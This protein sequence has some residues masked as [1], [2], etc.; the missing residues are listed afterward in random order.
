MQEQLDITYTDTWDTLH[1]RLNE[2]QMTYQECLQS[3][4]WFAAVRKAN[5]RGCYNLCEFC[6]SPRDDLH[7]SSYKLLLTQRELRNVYP[8]CNEHHT[9]L[10]N[11]ARTYG[12]SVRLATNILRST[13]NRLSRET[14]EMINPHCMKE[15]PD[16][17][18]QYK[19]CKTLDLLK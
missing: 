10:H 6:N 1:T 15:L 9:M 16:F 18:R 3:S 7:H 4:L 17:L 5:S 8:A 13:E 14:I 2:L 19:P 11:L 12:I